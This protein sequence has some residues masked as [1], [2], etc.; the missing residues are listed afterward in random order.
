MSCY[1][2]EMNS[3]CWPVLKFLFLSVFN[4]LRAGLFWHVTHFRVLHRRASAGGLEGLSQLPPG[5]EGLMGHGLHPPG[6]PPRH[7]QP[8]RRPHS[9]MSGKLGSRSWHPTPFTSDDEEGEHHFFKEEKKN[10]I[11]MEISRRR[12]QIEENA[13]LHEELIRLARLRE[14]AEV[15]GPGVGPSEAHHHQQRL[16]VAGVYPSPALSPGREGNAVLRSVDEILRTEHGGPRGHH[17]ARPGM[18][19]R[20][21]SEDIG[22]SFNPDR[23]TASVYDRVTD[24]S[25]VNSDFSNELMFAGR[26]DPGLMAGAR[27]THSAR[28]NP[29]R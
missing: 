4:L 8:N 17:A 13:R 1:Y 16:G 18:S 12:H 21:H 23:Y 24:F 20:L 28:S 7:P 25:P 3:V 14:N 15:G 26:G 2:V 19:R 6:H 11:K 27:H 22:G 5:A 10:R 9:S 29:Y